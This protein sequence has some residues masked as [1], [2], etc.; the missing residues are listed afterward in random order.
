MCENDIMK[1][2][3]ILPLALLIASC[4]DDPAV[5]IARARDEIA[6]MELGAARVDLTAALVAKGDDV[7]LLK[8]LADVQLRLG[9]GDGAQASADR[10][11]RLGFKGPEL[12][13]INAEAA[14]LRGKAEQALVMLADDNST[15]AWRVRAAARIALKDTQGGVDAMRRGIAAGDDPLLLRDYARFL[16]DAEDLDGAQQQVA[17]L[18]RL[19]PDNFDAFMLS[20]DIAAR[21]GK[22]ADAHATLERAAKRYPKLADPWI[23][24]AK[25]YD[26]AGKLDDAIAMTEKAAALA[27]D[28][29]GVIDLKVQ[30]AAMQGNWEEVRKV[31]SVQESTLDPV[32]TNGLTYAEA[33]LRT[34]HPEQARAMFQRALTR[35][36]NNPYSRLMLAQSQLATG[37]A[38]AAYATVRP[39]SDSFLAG[40]EELELAERAARA[41]G[42]ADADVLKARLAAVRTSQTAELNRKG[43]NALARE[44][45]SGAIAAYGQL[46]QLGKDAEVMKRL[47]MALSRAGRTD[48]AIKAADEARA[49]RPEDPDMTY[50]AGYVRAAGGRDREVALGLLKQASDKDPANALFKRSL[51][52]FS[53]TQGG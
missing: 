4:G 41:L 18:F 12:A 31:L 30:F 17:A 15:T 42:S 23:A 2:A 39:L 14:L 33:M 21:R 28:D 7:E 51:A 22:M 50:M 40:P 44:D 19:V 13:R 48:D 26:M 37:D 35:S 43:R 5:R 52:R 36:P 10:L 8:L 3:L 46:A 47:A 29:R 9:D 34:D 53:T 49:L 16:I 27:P 38:A 25:A 32:S 1:K 20:A 11:E 45:W 24:R 6:G